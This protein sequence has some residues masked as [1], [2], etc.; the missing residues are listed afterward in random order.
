MSY[1]LVSG[2][3]IGFVV[4][5]AVALSLLADTGFWESVVGAVMLVGVVALFVGSCFAVIVG[6]G[7][8]M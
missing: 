1:L 3:I 6:I 7:D 4:C 2:G 8:L 5:I